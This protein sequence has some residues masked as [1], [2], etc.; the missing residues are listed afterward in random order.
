LEQLNI[1]YIRLSHR[2]IDGLHLWNGNFSYYDGN[3]YVQLQPY[4]INKWY[5]IILD[6]ECSNGGYKGLNQYEWRVSINGTDYNNLKMLKEP[7]VIDS[8]R[9]NTAVTDSG[10][11]IYLDVINFSWYNEFE[12]EKFLFNIDY[13]EQYLHRFNISY[14]IHTYQETPFNVNVERYYLDIDDLLLNYFTLKL[15]EYGD[16]VVYSSIS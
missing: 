14:F 3:Q 4:Q 9:F 11:E 12:V 7:S 6:F 5:H 2:S 13:M 15:Y 1:I 10:W 16:Y 8:L